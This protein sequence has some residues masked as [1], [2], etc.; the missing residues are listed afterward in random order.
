MPVCPGVGD[1]EGA[2]RAVGDPPVPGG[3]GR[4][5]GHVLGVGS[6]WASLPRIGLQGVARRKPEIAPESL[7]NANPRLNSWES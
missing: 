3:L 2:E 4:N 7:C 1:S 5:A 6:L